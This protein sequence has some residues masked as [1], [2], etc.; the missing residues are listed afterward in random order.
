MEVVLGSG[1]GLELGVGMGLGMGLGMGMCMELGPD[2]G[3]GMGLDGERELPAELG[4]VGTGLES[5]NSFGQGSLR[6]LQP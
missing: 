1:A 2:L 4:V 3:L 5:S 6:P